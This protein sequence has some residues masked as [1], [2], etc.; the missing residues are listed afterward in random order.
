[1]SSAR[2]L[3]TSGTAL[4]ALVLAAATFAVIQ[5]DR[6]GALFAAAV[7]V[8]A[9][10]ELVTVEHGTP[11]QMLPLP[12]F[13][14]PAFT[15]ANAVA[16][17]MNLGRLGL[18]FLLTQFLHTVQQRSTLCAGAAVLPLFL[19][20]SLLGPIAGRLTAHIGPRVPILVGLL[21]AVLGVGQ[22]ATWPA[23]SPYVQL[24]PAMLCWGVGLGFLTPAA[25]AVALGAVPPEWDGIA[26]GTNN[27]ARRAGG[28]IGVAA[29]GSVAGPP[30]TVTRFL[31]GLYSPGYSPALSTSSPRWSP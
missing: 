9:L 3:D 13:R 23:A 8:V 31:S 11:D 19:P 26:S 20:L 10:A 7:A 5:W 16:G 28:A 27:T 6:P 12:L 15:A 22:L 18:L 14:I 21:V 1:V 17:I 30:G 25:V 24:V 4:G 2:R 29:F